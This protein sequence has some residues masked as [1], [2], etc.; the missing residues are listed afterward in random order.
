[1][2]TTSDKL[3]DWKER[4]KIVC[5]CGKDIVT[6]VCKEASCPHLSMQ[7]LYCLDCTLSRGFHKH[8]PA[9]FIKD[10]INSY[11]SMWEKSEKEL[12]L[13][14]TEAALRYERWK[15]LILYYENEMRHSI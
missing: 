5:Q 4:C 8:N 2:L 7:P 12:A 6:F 9:V 14:A 1:M 11:S 10:E 15:P 3:N 13:I